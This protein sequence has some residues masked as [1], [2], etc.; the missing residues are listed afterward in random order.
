M[1]SIKTEKNSFSVPTRIIFCIM[2][3]KKNQS[4]IFR[5]FLLPQ[6][7]SVTNYMLKRKLFCFHLKRILDATETV[8]D[9]KTGFFFTP[10]TPDA[11]NQ[12]IEKFENSSLNQ[13]E[14]IARGREFSTS[15]FRKKILESLQK[16]A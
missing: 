4:P 7:K 11:L 2:N 16:Y 14:I 6:K 8:V 9:E 5:G 15:N 1:P 12:I 3:Y 10:Q 13:H